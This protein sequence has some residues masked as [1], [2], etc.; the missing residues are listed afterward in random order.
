MTWQFAVGAPGAAEPSRELSSASGRSVTWRLD[1]PCGATF[2]LDARHEEAGEVIDKVSDLW[3]RRDGVLLF[4][5]R[6][7]AP[8][9]VLGADRHTVAWQAIDRR[10]HL[11]RRLIGAVPPTFTG[12]DQHAIAWQLVQHTQTMSGGNL[13]ITD[14]A[15]PTSGTLRNRTDIATGKPIGDLLAELGRVSG[16][17]EWEIDA[18]LKLNRWTPQRGTVTGHVLDYGGVVAAASSSPSVGDDGNVA[19]ALG[20]PD[21]T[22]A[23]VRQSATI[24]TDP[25]GRWEIFDGQ[26]SVTQQATVAAR[27]AWLLAAAEAERPDWV[28]KLTPGRWNGRADWWLGDTVTLVIR[29]GDLDISEP[30]RVGEI[31]VSIGASGEEIVTVGLVT[32]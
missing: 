24:G 25:R 18:T 13:G 29:D 4:R 32:S 22:T 1:G 7:V 6:C 3:V 26:P 14:G 27:A 21:A 20:S 17:F 12:V 23:E 5:G 2:A 28:V 15:N 19:I 10:G 31:S 9:R 8:S 30:A 16:G 11:R